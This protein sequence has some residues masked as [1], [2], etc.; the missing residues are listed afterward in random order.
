[1]LWEGDG[2]ATQPFPEHNSDPASTAA[3]IGSFKK[4]TIQRKLH[5]RGIYTLWKFKKRQAT[6]LGFNRIT[7]L[8]AAIILE[9]LAQEKKKRATK[10][11]V[12]K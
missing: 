1:M 6:S 12:C 5:K 2:R 9:G 7:H 8:A 4:I 10:M 11:T 3:V